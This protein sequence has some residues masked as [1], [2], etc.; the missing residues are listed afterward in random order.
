D[1][2]GMG[3]EFINSWVSSVLTSYGGFGLNITR[4]Y[5]D[6]VFSWNSENGRSYVLST[7]NL[8]IETYG[9]KGLTVYLG[10]RVELRIKSVTINSTN[11][12]VKIEF[13]VVQGGSSGKSE[14]IPNLTNDY[15]RIMVNGTPV[16]SFILAYLRQGRYVAS[17][18]SP[19]EL[20]NTI[21]TLTVITPEDNVIVS[22]QCNTGIFR[23]PTDGENPPTNNPG[24]DWS[25]LYLATNGTKHMIILSPKQTDDK[26]TFGTPPRSTGQS[27]T[28][29]IESSNTPL[30]ITLADKI[31]ITLYMEASKN[32]G[33]DFTIN[34]TVTFGYRNSTGYYMIGNESILVGKQQG[35]LPQSSYNLTFTVDP[36]IKDV[37]SGSMFELKIEATFFGGE[38]TLKIFLGADTPSRVKLY[39]PS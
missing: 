14:P 18:Y 33:K 29:I 17:F 11:N 12:H 24:E 37:P 4:G 13:Q 22:A 15:T 5:A 1:A 31:N 38:G 28:V 39:D 30:D 3:E 23:N 16:E 2:S 36:S 19:I 6:W 9:L 34:V 27:E 20:N 26:G 8:D 32:K 7:F 21:I 35:G 25:T 10:K